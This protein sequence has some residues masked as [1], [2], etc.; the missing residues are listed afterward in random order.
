MKL[1][2]LLGGVLGATCCVALWMTANTHSELTNLR[3]E[4]QRLL[5]QYQA[6]DAASQPAAT[7]DNSFT[8]SPEL[9]QLRR[10]VDGLIER[11]RA[12]SGVRAENER[13]HTQVATRATNAPA[14]MTLPPGYILRTQAKWMGYSSPENSIQS[15]LWAIQNHDL[16]NM[17][18]AVTPNVVQSIQE[19]LQRDGSVDKFFEGADHLPGMRIVDQTS[20]SDGSILLR[21]QIVPSDSDL[22]PVSARFIDGQWKLDLR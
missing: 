21:V 14:A 15:L 6:P 9:L 11:Q 4:K 17:L 22:Q 16:T 5:V 1:R 19:Q 2:L 10:Q 7:A 20:Q 8:P 3:A 13:L 12:L 18:Q